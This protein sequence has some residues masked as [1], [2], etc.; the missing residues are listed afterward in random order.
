MYTKYTCGFVDKRRKD[1]VLKDDDPSLAIETFNKVDHNKD[2][3]ISKKEIKAYFGKHM[4]AGDLDKE[5][6]KLDKN[7]SG[8]IEAQEF[9]SDI[10]EDEL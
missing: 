5:F 8:F 7:K 10:Q 3:K 2:K 4:K 1:Q 9:D 6:S